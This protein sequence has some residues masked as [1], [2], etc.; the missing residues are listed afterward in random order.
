MIEVGREYEIGSRRIRV[1]RVQEHEGTS[2]V[3][4]RNSDG[5]NI[6]H[7]CSETW[8]YEDEFVSKWTPRESVG[9]LDSLDNIRHYA[10]RLPA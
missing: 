9:P 4:Y 6:T 5:R 8:E 1:V 3:W 2:K 10:V 7:Q